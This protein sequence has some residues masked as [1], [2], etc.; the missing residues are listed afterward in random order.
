[1][2][3]RK[4]NYSGRLGKVPRAEY[5]SELLMLGAR[6]YFLGFFRLNATFTP[7]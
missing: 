7:C 1:M 6:A 5:F 2:P 4:K 3:Q